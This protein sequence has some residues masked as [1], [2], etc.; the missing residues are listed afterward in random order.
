[1]LDARTLFASISRF[2]VQLNTEIT[3]ACTGASEGSIICFASAAL[4]G[5][6]M[7]AV[8]PRKRGSV[9]PDFLVQEARGLSMT[10]LPDLLY[11]ALFAVALPLLDYLVF[12]PAFRRRS[13]ADPARAEP[14]A[15]PDR[16]ATAGEPVVRRAHCV[17]RAWILLE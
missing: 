6:V 1:M 16:A 14:G 13:Q 9:M 5:P 10:A 15:G 8:R 4:D 3:K 7:P 2:R 11:V 17:S 12:W